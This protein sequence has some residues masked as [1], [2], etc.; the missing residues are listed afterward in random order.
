MHPRGLADVELHLVDSLEEANSLY[1]WFLHGPQQHGRMAVDTETS[2]LSRQTD[3]VRLVQVGDSNEGWAIPWE[4]PDNWAGLFTDIMSRYNGRIL[5]HNGPTFDRPMIRNMGLELPSHSMDDTMV[6]CHILEPLLPVALKKAA[7]RHVDPAAN[8]AQKE[9]EEAI[10]KLGWAGVPVKFPPFW[11]YAALDP[12][13]TCQLEEM[14]RPKLITQGCERAY[15]V[16]LAVLFTLE[17]MSSNGAAVDVGY[18]QS[19][20]ERFMKYVHDAAVWCQDTFGCSPGSNQ[21]VIKVLQ[22]AG[23]EFT[24]FTESGALAL[25][26]E[27]LE[28]IDHPLAQT[29]LKRRQLEKLSSTYLSFY[30]EHHRDGRI[31]PSIRSL[32]AR[33]GRMS[34]A[35]PNFQNLPRV[36]EN[37]PSANVVRNCITASPGNVLIFCDFSQIETRILAHLSQDAGL[38]AAFHSPEDF[39]VTLARKIFRDPS[40]GKK[41]PRRNV[42]KTLV[43]A[44]IYG[45]GVE[46]MALTLGMPVSEVYAVNS[47]LNLAFPGIKFFQ[48]D[49]QREGWDNK[50]RHGEVFVRCPL[51]GRR[52]FADPG[53]EY[54]L[55]NYLIQGMAAFFFKTKLLELDAAGLAEYMILP[56]HDEIILD[57][58]VEK[59]PEV[60]RV[61]MEVMN[62]THT[63]RVPVAAEVSW[64]PRWGK[65]HDW[66]EWELAA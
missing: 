25:D 55:V 22:D 64:G 23:Y 4:G 53:K 31:H 5:T 56:V 37:N 33:T 20:R 29:V 10:A 2:G 42:I 35:E 19:Q 16:E 15:D 17:R 45:A 38:I 60:V 51:S 21:K 66:S 26:K 1:Q 39:F 48:D 32:G 52:H 44:K 43:Y 3:R 24:K 11:A 58:P 54:A 46:K 49:V 63:L 65:K 36:S 7:G 8:A 6:M 59:A 47:D 13:L 50:A 27:V 57:V 14:L 12:V 41:D 30:I 18:A 61:L 34:M 28:D 62:D 9:L 40:I